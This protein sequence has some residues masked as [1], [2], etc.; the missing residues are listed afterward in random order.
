MIL[1][2][3]L[4]MY[5]YFSIWR[6]GFVPSLVGSAICL[7]SP[8]FVVVSHMTMYA[9]PVQA[10]QAHPSGDVTQSVPWWLKNRIHGRRS[11]K[12]LTPSITGTLLLPWAEML[13]QGVHLALHAAS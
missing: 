8:S 12:G 10:L 9:F 11:D 13:L 1:D 4:V 5:F 3:A 6:R 2:R 7:A